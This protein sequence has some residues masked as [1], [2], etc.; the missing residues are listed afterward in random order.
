MEK[1]LKQD[2]VMWGAYGRLKGVVERLSDIT[3]N[4]LQLFVQNIVRDVESQLSQIEHEERSSETSPDDEVW[5]ERE[6]R[7]QKP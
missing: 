4:D 5:N 6:Q 2:L 7:W 1:M 3:Y